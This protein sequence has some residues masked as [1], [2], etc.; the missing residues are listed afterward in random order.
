MAL[1]TACVSFQPL[2]VLF[3]DQNHIRH[4]RWMHV[5]Y[6]MRCKLTALIACSACCLSSLELVAAPR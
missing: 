2:S 3:A 4:E 1:S 6:P 5:C